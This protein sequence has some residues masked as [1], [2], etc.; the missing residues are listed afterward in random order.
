MTFLE[1]CDVMEAYGV[2]ELCFTYLQKKYVVELIADN[3][4]QYVK[5]GPLKTAYCVNFDE[6]KFY[7]F[8][9]LLRAQV[10]DGRTLEEIWDKIEN[11]SF[12]NCLTEEEFWEEA[13]ES[14]FAERMEKSKGE[15]LINGMEVW[16]HALSPKQSF[17]HRFKFAVL[18]ILLI[19]AVLQVF[20]V[21]GLVSWYF[22][23]LIGGAVLIALICAGIAVK[24]AG[25][26]VEY[27]VTDKYVKKFDGKERRISYNN[28][29]DVKIRKYL[30]KQGYG[31]VKIYSNKGLFS[32]LRMVQIPNVQDVYE[33]ITEIWQDSQHPYTD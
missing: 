5:G 32:S 15:Y 25:V 14:T 11:V 2:D 3:Y 1:Y 28:I 31:T 9:D 29:R 8:D 13:D 33:L 24:K 6:H 27:V 10:F 26:T 21:L 18:G 22:E 7:S 19:P 23:L 16:S 4:L 12:N 20:P 30:N 17:R